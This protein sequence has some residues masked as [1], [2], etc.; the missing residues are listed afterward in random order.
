MSDSALFTYVVIPVLIFLARIL[1]VSVGTLR[2]IFVAKGMKYLAPILG[3]FEVLI[4]LLA[5]GQI[6]QNLSNWINYVAYA[7][8]FAAGN[9]IGMIIELRLALGT[10][11][12]RVITNRDASKLVA[13]MREN[14]FGVT[15]VEAEGKSGAVKI[16]FAMIARTEL[17]KIIDLVHKYNP[18]AFYSVE[19]VRVVNQGIFPARDHS[20]KHTFKKRSRW[21]K[22]RK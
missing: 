17:R 14:N 4:W 6:L 3:F 13:I 16:L 15:S 19:D 21:L 22:N 9:Y 18:N 1:D 8:G 11:I 5:I 2:M 7:G 20:L 10:V 12:L